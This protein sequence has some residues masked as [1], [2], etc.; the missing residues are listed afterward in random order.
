MI[1]ITF[2]VALIGSLALGI[3]VAFALLAAGVAL[4][5]QLD[6]FSAQIVAQ[7]II[8]GANNF[9]LLAVPFFILA[10]EAMN[11]GGMSRRLVNLA[12]SLIGHKHGGLGYVAI[13]ATVL[14]ASMSGSAVADTAAIG[15]ILIPMLRESNYE[16]G[17]SS[18]VIASGGI[19]A[20]IIPPSIPFIVFGA[21]VQVSISKLFMAGIFPGILMGC[22]CLLVWA[23][24]V[25]NKDM[26][27][28][29]KKSKQ[30]I[31]KSLIDSSLALMIPVII[32]GGI[33][34]GI[35]TPTESGV[36][37]AVYALFIGLF[38]YNEIAIRDLYNIFLAAGRLT[39]VIMFLVA[40][41]AV[42][43]WMLTIANLPDKL[44][45]LLHPLIDTPQ[46]LLGVIAIVTLIIG[47]SMDL[48]P[49]ILILGPVLMPVIKEAGID[50]VYFGVIFIMS[51]AIGLITPPVGNVLNVI[52]GVSKISLVTASKGVWPF[53]A[54][55]MLLL[56]LL[57]AVPQ[58]VT[59][60][61]KLLIA[62]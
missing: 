20:P 5:V 60:P 23:L 31:F 17:T 24:I 27:V 47:T 13:F 30:Y 16:I 29:E 35:F 42:S 45:V 7:N 28:F 21:T 43:A 22:S 8:N 52:C 59:V 40:A 9:S 18:G 58:L 6:F 2:L 39:A 50:P 49:I 10:G 38:V 33:R 36:V 51:T 56:F 55:Y 57:I 32:V 19:I 4:M 26:P 11:A 46:L 62:G 12:M 15:A 37:A 1:V 53:I 14:M 41:A 34:F 54:A 25:R 48:I 61:M 44:I 3:P